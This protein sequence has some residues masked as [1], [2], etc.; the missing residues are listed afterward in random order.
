MG[1]NVMIMGSYDRH[2]ALH[3]PDTLSSPHKF[4][5]YRP[6]RFAH[7]SALYENNIELKNTPEIRQLDF[8]IAV[9]I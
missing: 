9:T 2:I 4:F 1:L 7:T 3:Q 8:Q 5:S 6:V